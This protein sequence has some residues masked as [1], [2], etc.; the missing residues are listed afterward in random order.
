[1]S[2][3]GVVGNAG[4]ITFN[5]ANVTNTADGDITND[6]VTIQ[7]TTQILDDAVEMNAGDSK[8]NTARVT[9]SIN[10]TPVN[11]NTISIDIIEPNLVVSI[12]PSNAMPSLGEEVT[13]TVQVQNS[14]GAD[15]FDVD[16]ATLLGDL[17]LTY[18]GGFNANGSG[19]SIDDADPDS[20]AFGATSVPA[21]NTVSFTFNATVD[22]DA[23]LDSLM[24]V[25][26]GLTDAYSSQPNTPSNPFVER[27]Y[28]V[29]T[30]GSVTPSLHVIEAVKTVSFTD[31]NANDQLDPG[32]TVS[33]TIVLSNN[34]GATANNVVFTDMIPDQ[35]TYVGASLTTSAGTIDESNAPLLSVDVGTMSAA[36]TVT[37]NFDVTV[38][39]GTANG[40]L[41]SNQGFVD[42]DETEPEPTDWDG[43]DD[44]GDQPTDIMVGPRP[45]VEYALYAPK[46]V[47]WLTD[48]DGSGDITAGDIMR[49]TFILENRGDA[50]L[51]GVTLT[52]IIPSGLS[53]SAA[54]TPTEG[55]LN[56]G[57]F[58]NISWTG[59]T[60]DVGENASVTLDV[61]IDAFA[62]AT[63]SFSNQGTADANETNASETDGNNEPTDGNQ[64]TIFEAVNGGSG[65]AGLDVEKRWSISNDVD[66]DGLVDPG[67]RYTYTIS[68]RNSGNAPASDVQFADAAPANTSLAG[69]SV[70]TSQGIIV[71]E[72]DANVAVNIGTLNPGDIALVQMEVSVDG[73]TADGT[74]IPNQ[75]TASS[76][77]VNSG[78]P[79]SSDDNGDDNDGLNPTITPVHTGTGTLDAADLSKSISST[80]ESQSSGTNVF[81]G[82]VL[83]YQIE[84]V[85]PRGNLSE[86]ALIDTMPGGLRYVAGSAQLSRSFQTGL[87]ASND[88][89]GINA[90]ASGSGVSLSDGSDISIASNRIIRVFLGSVINSD[91]ETGPVVDE[92][93]TLSF[94]AVVSNESGIGNDAGAS[95]N[96]DG[97][98]EYV[99]GINQPQTLSTASDPSVTINEPN[100][101]VSKS[102]SS[103]YIL[104]AGG[105][106]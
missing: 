94:Q 101:T 59:I 92:T 74:L 78:T 45:E 7:L 61:S 44:N 91:T 54:G 13:F 12:T 19:F 83:T 46:L 36:A 62:P 50:Q 68:I 42:S 2:D 98:F 89:G 52:D 70:S 48:T 105:M 104:T 21:G 64:P 84:I 81:I 49:Y 23:T 96:N 29:N 37:I 41:L 67:D 53:F 27:D 32:E 20:L 63:A 65:T 28:D 88:P 25:I 86:A 51:T 31:G 26:I 80:S 79:V 90:A 38:D 4:K 39:G 15:A 69:D 14:G 8:S 40:T 56:T 30:S 5:L 57:S 75:A 3:D 9:S 95:L 100:L 97:T 73:G 18:S 58:P 47:Q 55:S 66:G 106:I 99:D 60:L 76:P 34:T 35:T 16:M 6:T 71:S 24:N 82:E 93:Y 72:T 103:S 1:M 87:T 11:S 43:V 22:D 33:Y 10:A 77:E 102:A 17:Y 85:V